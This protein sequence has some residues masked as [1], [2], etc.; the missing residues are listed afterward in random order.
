MVLTNSEYLLFTTLINHFGSKFLCRQ[1][2][3]TNQISVFISFFPSSVSL[4]R[5]DY[6]EL[7]QSFFI[8]LLMHASHIWLR[9]GL[10]FSLCG[11]KSPCQQNTL[12]SFCSV[13]LA[14]GHVGTARSPSTISQNRGWRW[15]NAYECLLHSQEEQ[16]SAPAPCDVWVSYAHLQSQL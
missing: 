11:L 12:N 16:S 5:P 2:N 6:L 14:A 10:S 15:L 3:R 7:E 1:V 13:Y 8:S 9:L 4:H